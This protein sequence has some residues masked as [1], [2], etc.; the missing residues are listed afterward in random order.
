MGLADADWNEV[1]GVSRLR[2]SPTVGYP[3]SHM[4]WDTH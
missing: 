3:A 1:L 2:D 4:H